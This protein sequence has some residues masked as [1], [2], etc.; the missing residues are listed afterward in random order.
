MNAPRSHRHR[1]KLLL[2]CM[3]LCACA[4]N[5]QEHTDLPYAVMAAR[6]ADA[7]DAQ[8]GERAMVRYDPNVFADLV[9]AVETALQGGGVIVELVPYGETPDY[10]AR[11]NETD[12]YIWLP[13]SM[14]QPLPIS[15][16]RWANGSIRAEDD[17]STSIG[18]KV[19]S[20]PTVLRENT[21]RP[22]TASTWLHSRSTMTHSIGRKRPQSPYSN[23]TPFM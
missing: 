17:R 13:V 2:L 5:A 23:R 20:V 8:S 15:S 22:T 10:A 14:L 11:L 1:G 12:I 18:D 7:L 16:L 9:P 6:I 4:Q 19:R 3:L 21:R